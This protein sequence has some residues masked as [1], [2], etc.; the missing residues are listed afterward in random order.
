MT[1]QFINSM[2]SELQLQRLLNW[3]IIHF[4]VSVPLFRLRIFDCRRLVFLLE[5]FT[6]PGKAI[7][8]GAKYPLKI[9]LIYDSS[10]WWFSMIWLRVT[11]RIW[12]MIWSFSDSGEIWI[13][14]YDSMSSGMQIAI[15]RVVSAFNRRGFSSFISSLAHTS[16]CLYNCTSTINHSSGATKL[17]FLRLF[18]SCWG[19]S[20]WV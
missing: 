3:I 17:I 1:L 14:R 6:I 12:R 20:C 19:I 15:S 11:L 2:F 5:D 7:L 10:I 13:F 16:P 4:Y 18:L 9:I 8:L